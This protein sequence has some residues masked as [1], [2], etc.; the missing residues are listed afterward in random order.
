MNINDSEYLKSIVKE[1]YGK[2]AEQSK[3]EN[4]T[5]CCGTGCC[6]TVDYA[7][8]AE[9]Y[10][11]LNG[12]N[13]DAD[14]GLGCG[15]PTEFA[16][17][18]AGDTVVDL[19][20]GAGNDVFI[21]RAIAG[22]KAGVIIIYTRAYWVDIVISFIIA[23][24]ILI[25]TWK[26]FIDSIRLALDGIPGGIELDK[27]QNVILNFKEVKDVHHVH[28]W[29]ISST[30]NALTAHLVVSDKDISKFET[31]KN[32]IKHE[33][34]HLNIQHTTFEIEYGNCSDNHK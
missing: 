14:L 31:V 10:T 30:E 3:T 2:I 4:E 33:L 13:P 29:P 20:S 11:K 17:I 1:Q 7:V 24:V 16:Q 15:L 27:V 8:F 18:K 34:E 5:S 32:E 26:L 23:I 9:D 12:Y 22:E 19:G 25:S 6:E 28:I 21:A